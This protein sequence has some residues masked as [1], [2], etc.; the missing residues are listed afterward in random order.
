MY[1]RSWRVPSEAMERASSCRPAARDSHQCPAGALAAAPVA[2]MVPAAG[3]GGLAYCLLGHLQPADAAL[4]RPPQQ[5]NAT[6]ARA[7]AAAAATRACIVAGSN[8]QLL[9][10]KAAVAVHATA[11]ATLTASAGLPRKWL[12]RHGR[13]GGALAWRRGRQGIDSLD[14]GRTLTFDV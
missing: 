2:W 12:Q 4:R 14:A 9:H 3:R 5:K 8:E 11:A 7:A 10:R 1:Q 6:G 13:S